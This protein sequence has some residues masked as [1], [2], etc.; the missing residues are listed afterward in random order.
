M[1][2]TQNRGKFIAMGGLALVMFL[3]SLDQTIVGTAMPRIVAELQGFELYAW[4]T[5]AYLLF[6]TAVIPVV[7][8]LGDI[9]G[10]KWLLI[11][12]VVV[13][14][15][16][17]A[18]CGM[19]QS[20]VWLIIGR[21][22]Q[23]VGGGMIFATTFALMADIFPDL[24]ERARYQGFLFSVFTLSSVLGPVIGG[25]ITDTIGWRWLFYINIPLGAITLFVLPKVLPL[26]ER[27]KAKIDYLGAFTSAVGVI[28][29]L[30][31]VEMLN[32]GYAW[33]SPLIL[34]GI[35]TGLLLLALFVF[36]ETR[37]ADPIIPMHIFRNRTL[38][39]TTAIMFMNS[40]AMFGV[41]LY[42]PLF[43]Q[44]VLGVSPTTSGTLMIPMSIMMTL[45]GII[46]GQL[47]ARFEAVKPFLILGHVILIIG[48]FLMLTLSPSSNPWLMS[49]FL[50]IFAL[51]LGG[52][53]PA[54]GM[55]VQLAVNPREIGVAM[56]AT[57]Y[58]RS[59][60]ATI[61]TAAIGMVVTNQYLSRFNST[62]PSE[63]PAEAAE[64]L[65]NPN[66]LINA[67]EMDKLNSVLANVSNSEGV[68]NMLLE[69]TR[70]GLTYAIHSGFW[71][72]IISTIISLGFVLLTSNLRLTGGP[73][74]GGPVH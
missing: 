6:E 48:G 5:T 47:M 3:V 16:T 32:F 43:A 64:I 15:I 39:A 34:G 9:F 45:M 29:L 36:I 62:L 4:V 28:I 13:F 54:T 12:G 18:I 73:R 38:S 51:G 26:N 37:V 30:L 17:S 10:R 68:L 61:G 71:V 14:L 57:Q 60:G 59:I 55:M 31:S 23:G 58:I 69:T 44:G 70:N 42:T 66:A 67:E 72:M 35:I 19:A 27:Q 52:L 24:K 65:H 33:N 56:A 8:K 41:I 46:V 53:M 74:T 1:E 20:M 50:F 21:G 2:S 40:I 25:T 49:F 11:W 7:G 63:V 22:L